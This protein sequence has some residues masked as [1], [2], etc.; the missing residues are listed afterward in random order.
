M[1]FDAIFQQINLRYQRAK[2]VSAIL[3]LNR[4]NVDI[5]FFSFKYS[6]SLFTLEP[7]T[8]TPLPDSFEC[9][10]DPQRSFGNPLRTFRQSLANFSAI[11]CELFG[12]TLRVLF[13]KNRDFF[14]YGEIFLPNTR[15]ALGCLLGFWSSGPKPCGGNTLRLIFEIDYRLWASWCQ[16]VETAS[17][18]R[19]FKWLRKWQPLRFYG[20]D[21]RM[22]GYCW[23]KWAGLSARRWERDFEVR[24]DLKFW[25]FRHAVSHSGTSVSQLRENMT[26][27]SRYYGT[28]FMTK[29]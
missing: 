15:G 7:C 22:N 5:I 6:S 12:N 29:K 25:E 27:S 26:F 9:F 14:C 8:K 24:K 4:R 18:R 3:T 28:P 23:G 13:L 17:G 10:F 1:D 16:F 20:K 11:P 19:C 21:N 2:W